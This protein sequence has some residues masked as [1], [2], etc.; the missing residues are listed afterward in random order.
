MHDQILRAFCQFLVPLPAFWTR[1][2]SDWHAAIQHRVQ[3]LLQQLPELWI[4][5]KLLMVHE[6][7]GTGCG[8]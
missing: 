6:T 1:P 3:E 5:C 2:E 7:S 4:P 8:V